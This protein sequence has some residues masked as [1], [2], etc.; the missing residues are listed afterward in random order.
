MHRLATIL[1]LL[2]AAAAPVHAEELPDWYAKAIK[3]DDPN[4][5]AYSLGIQDDCPFTNAK[6]KE[7]VEGV[8][9]RSRVK[10]TEDWRV[11]HIYLSVTVQCIR[12]PERF[13]FFA[14]QIDV[15]FGAIRSNEAVLFDKPFGNYGYTSSSEIQRTLKNGVEKAINA[16]LKA[17]FDL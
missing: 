12:D 10:P 17:N 9:V 5:L 3:K 11:D 8:F 6:A 16:Y 7:I 13:D 15:M 14:Y 1:P 4:E 2:L